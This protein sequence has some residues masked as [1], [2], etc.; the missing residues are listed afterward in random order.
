MIEGGMFQKEIDDKK[1]MAVPTVFLNGEEFSSGRMT[2]EQIVEKIT[3]PLIEEELFE[4]EPYDVL[5]IGGGPAASSAAI[6]A[7]RKGIRTGL[8]AD[9]FGG[10]VVETLG[11]ENMIGTSY[12][13]GPKLMQ[14]VESH[15]R[16]YPIDIMMN[17]QAVSL[18]KEQHFINIGLANGIS[19]KAKPP[20]SRQVRTGVLSMYQAKKSLKIKELLIAHTV[21]ALYLKEKRLLLSVVVILVLKQQSIWLG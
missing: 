1:I 7:A 14:Q 20:S 13:E 10:Q 15:V 18:N 17:Q 5:V 2:I 12:T 11:I 3:G 8:V 4:K 9:S 21:T 16:S 19:L 6:Y